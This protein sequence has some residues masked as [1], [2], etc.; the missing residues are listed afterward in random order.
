MS[1]RSSPKR[2]RKPAWVP[3]GAYADLSNPEWV[4]GQVPLGF[5]ED[6]K[7]HKR[8][9]KWLKRELSLKTQADWYQLS[10]K[11][12]VSR[13]GGRLLSYYGN[14]H[15]VAICTLVK[16]KAWHPWKFKYVTK[17][18]WE[19]KR[20]QRDYMRWL[21]Q[22][23]GYKRPEDW[24]RVSHKAVLE[25]HGKM[26]LSKVGLHNALADL[27]PEF[28]WHIW[29]FNSV[30]NNYWRSEKNVK[31]YLKW[32][33]KELGFKK[34]NDWYQ[35]SK[36]A[37]ISNFGGSML[38]SQFQTV[39]A[40]AVQ[41]LYP[42]RKWHPWLFGKVPHGFWKRKTNRI[43]YLQ[44]LGKKLNFKKT[45]DWYKLKDQHFRENHGITL[46]E[47][48]YK[49]S[50][51]RAVRELFPDQTWHAWLF[52]ITP[53]NFFRRKQNRIAY[54]RWLIALRKKELGDNIFSFG[55]PRRFILKNHGRTLLAICNIKRVQKEISQLLELD[56]ISYT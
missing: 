55:F 50:P 33:G 44:W 10:S 37:F 26:L 45:A 40:K 20:N 28:E 52:A 42:N 29:K 17:S 31:K 19:S 36:E 14:S 22:E 4:Q 12:F 2:F 35:V 1:T 38:E 5:W 30:P 51:L 23:L 49:G 56:E 43:A 3:N 25:R 48:R 15:I 11:D 18:F 6:L 13:R 9:I 46:L 34:P 24:Y 8:Y 7:N 41:F 32:L 47:K 16:A 54:Y 27:Y 39:P 53:K 21:E